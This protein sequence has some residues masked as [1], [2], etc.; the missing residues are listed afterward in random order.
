MVGD[1]GIRLYLNG[2]LSIDGWRDH[3]ARVLMK[4]YEHRGGLLSIRLEY[5]NNGGKGVVKLDWERVDS[6]PAQATG[7]VSTLMMIVSTKHPA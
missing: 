2:V 1:D 7:L 3:P 4:D 6:A 5:Y